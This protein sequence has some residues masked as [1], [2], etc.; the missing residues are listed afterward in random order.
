M[1]IAEI[2][3]PIMEYLSPLAVW[4]AGIVIV[5]MEV[6][7]NWDTEKRFKKYYFWIGSGMSLIFAVLVTVFGG[8]GWAAFILHFIII[9]A[10]EFTIDA[11]I[12]KHFKPVL[13]LALDFL[14][15][16]LKG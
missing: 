1:S 16:L 13:P 6:L 15:K 3:G 7:K 8:F 11:G 12:V 4:A 14:K 5:L 9:F 10:G 2:V